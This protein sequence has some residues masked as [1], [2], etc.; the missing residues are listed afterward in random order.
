MD[1]VEKRNIII[2]PRDLVITKRKKCKFTTKYL[3][4]E[5]QAREYWNCDSEDEDVLDSGKCI[6]HDEYYL[7]D[8]LAFA[9]RRREMS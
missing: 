3:N 1:I 9:K 4:H 2:V 5:T 6:F 7:K 8:T